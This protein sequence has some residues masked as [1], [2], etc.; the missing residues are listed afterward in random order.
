MLRENTPQ[1]KSRFALPCGPLHHR[2][3]STHFSLFFPSSQFEK[4]D[5]NTAQ[6]HYDERMRKLVVFLKEIHPLTSNAVS[7]FKFHT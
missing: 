1:Y 4:H 7:S 2:V 5:R 6:Q 3:E